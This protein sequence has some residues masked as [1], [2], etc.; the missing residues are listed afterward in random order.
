MYGRKYNN[1]YG[2]EKIWNMDALFTERINQRLGE[3]DIATI[4]RDQYARY[5]ILQDI[6]INTHFKYNDKVVELKEKFNDVKKKLD[7]PSA[8]TSRSTQAQHIAVINSVAEVALDNLHFDIINLLYEA[9]LICL[10][11]QE[12]LN[13]ETEFERDYS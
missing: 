9:N 13:P 8:G 7:S 3:L 4:S 1:M 12:K 5:K 6:F 10:K 11:V 2:E